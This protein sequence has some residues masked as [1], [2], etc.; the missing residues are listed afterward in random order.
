MFKIKNSIFFLVFI[1][2]TFLS[3]TQEEVFEEPDNFSLI[4][5]KHTYTIDFSL[6]ISFKNTVFKGVMQGLVRAGVGYQYHFKNNL[7]LGLGYQYT[8]FQI[9][10]FKTPQ[11]IK[12]GLHINSIH[13]KIGREKFHNE[14]FATETNLKIGFSNFTFYSDS[15][16]RIN[17]GKNLNLTCLY[18]EPSLGLVLTGSAST[19]Y[20]W[21][22]SYSF[23][24][25]GFSPSNIGMLSSGGYKMEQFAKKT[26]FFSFGFAFAHYFKQR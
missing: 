2:L 16:T 23:Q 22:V 3:F 10:K 5:P 25:I 19:S 4:T 9:N 8:F 13:T 12:G 26:Q 6:P 11:Q 1:L 17:S 7:T 20:K 18:I 24:N 14:R 21:I 15:L